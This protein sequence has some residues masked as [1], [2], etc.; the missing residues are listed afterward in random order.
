MTNFGKPGN[1]DLRGQ[2]CQERISEEQ[3]DQCVELYYGYDHKLPR[4][5]QIIP[6]TSQPPNLTHVVA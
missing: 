3:G 5:G 6:P 1:T 2:L 4:D